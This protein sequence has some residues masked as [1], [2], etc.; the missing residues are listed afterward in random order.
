MLL[1]GGSPREKLR[2]HASTVEDT[3][4]QGDLIS[5]DEHGPV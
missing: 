4:S 5:D 1:D 3:R 2:I